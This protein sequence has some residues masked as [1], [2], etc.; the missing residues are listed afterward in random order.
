[1]T[2]TDQKILFTALAFLAVLMKGEDTERKDEA[3]KVVTLA[4]YIEA[5]CVERIG[6]LMPQPPE[7]SAEE[8]DALIKRHIQDLKQRHETRLPGD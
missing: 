8:T 2:R 5:F 4:E 1:M 7:A 6:D 3:Q